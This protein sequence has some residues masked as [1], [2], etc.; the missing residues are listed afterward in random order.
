MMGKNYSIYTRIADTNPDAYPVGCAC[1]LAHL[2]AKKAE[3]NCQ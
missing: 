2:C 1:H 3:I